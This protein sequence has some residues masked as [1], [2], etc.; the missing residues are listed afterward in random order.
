MRFRA[1]VQIAP[2]DASY[3][4]LREQWL[5]AE[6]LGLDTIW[7]W[8]H[9]FPL[10]G[11]PDAEHFEGWTFLAAMAEVTERAEFGVL[12][13][14][15]SYRNANLLAD[16][17]RT[18]DHASGG[19]LV[20]GL[21]AGWNERD[22]REYGYAYG[23]WATRVGAL[24]DALP[25]IRDRLGHLNP[26]PL[27]RIPIVLGGGGER[28]FLRLVAEHADEWNYV[29]TP[30][31]VAHKSAVLDGHCRAVGRGPAEVERSVL[32]PERAA[33]KDAEAYAAVGITHLIAPVAAPDFDYGPARR[34]LA[35]RDA[36]NG[37]SAG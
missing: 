2:Q 6:E 24:A 37:V 12:V 25:V 13:S 10:W 7:N 16:M 28:V 18:V 8:D 21:G 9:F 19:R 3:A 22:Y 36:A 34:L 14:C 5:R 30:D 35:W 23:D 26:P 17:A 33:A 4:A 32:L 11:D 15:N 31:E 20:L 29:G 1:G 27:R